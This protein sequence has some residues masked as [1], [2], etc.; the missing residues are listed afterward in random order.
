MTFRA[1]DLLFA[2]LGGILLA[3]GIWV[4]LYRLKRGKLWDTLL[5]FVS[6]VGFFINLYPLLY[7]C[8]TL[9]R[10]EKTSPIAIS[11][12]ILLAI[13][14]LFGGRLVYLLLVRLRQV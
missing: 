9:M 8:A 14:C 5:E 10:V 13:A 11:L 4:Y 3:A 1:L 7:D 12:T 6:G 2:V